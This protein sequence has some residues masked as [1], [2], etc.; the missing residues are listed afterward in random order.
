MRKIFIALFLIGAGI[1]L[2][3]PWAQQHFSGEEVGRWTLYQRG[4]GYQTATVNLK[5]DDAPVRIFIDVLPMQNH[6][7]I[8]RASSFNLAVLRNGIPVLAQT[9]NFHSQNSKSMRN[10]PQNSR[11]IRQSAGDLEEVA[12][13]VYEFSVRA[14]AVDGLAVTKA[15][16]ILRREAKPVSETITT[17]GLVV[18]IIGIYG[19]M[20]MRRRRINNS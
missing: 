6:A 7:P 9:L 11:E 4:Q 1:S 2:V 17:T 3:Y 18:M 12:D 10:T 16:L 15:D 19:F 5:A 8:E 13:G 20:R 14:G